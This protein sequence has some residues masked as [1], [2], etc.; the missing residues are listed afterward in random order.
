MSQQ[1][2]ICDRMVQTPLSKSSL[3]TRCRACSLPADAA[4][5]CSA[6]GQN[7]S[8]LQCWERE[9]PSALWQQ[10]QTLLLTWQEELRNCN[11]GTSAERPASTLAPHRRTVGCT[12]LCLEPQQSVFRAVGF[13]CS[14][15]DSL[16]LPELGSD[17]CAH[18]R[19]LFSMVQGK[20]TGFVQ[21]LQSWAGTCF[22]SMT[23]QV[24]VVLPP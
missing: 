23:D 6:M 2:Q 7:V 8:L 20:Q 19:K 17:G 10:W 18:G 16:G 22:S 12:E 3:N 4:G 11:Q 21:S 5:F 13:S 24:S 9:L 14:A 1:T 15:G